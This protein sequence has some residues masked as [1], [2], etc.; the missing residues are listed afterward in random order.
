MRQLSLE[1]LECRRMLAA[2]IQAAEG[3]PYRDDSLLVRYLDPGLADLGAL[4]PGLSIQRNFSS[5]P[6]LQQLRL[7]GGVGIHDALN[8]LR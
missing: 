2:S 5:V 1:T 4:V 3:L 6:G 7:P 8:A